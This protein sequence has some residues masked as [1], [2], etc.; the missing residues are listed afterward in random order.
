MLKRACLQILSFQPENKYLDTAVT[1][2]LLSYYYMFYL[3]SH[4]TICLLE[5]IHPFVVPLILSNLPEAYLFLS[6][7]E[8][9]LTM[10]QG[11]RRICVIE[12]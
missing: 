8:H 6:M 9:I 5:E 3:F 2:I 12:I 11:L 4:Y 10:Q 1:R 7:P